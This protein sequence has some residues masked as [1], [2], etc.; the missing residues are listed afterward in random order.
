MK[1]LNAYSGAEILNRL[2]LRA[3]NNRKGIGGPQS[4]VEGGGGISRTW[5]LRRPLF[6][7]VDCGRNGCRSDMIALRSSGTHNTSVRRDAVLQGSQ[8]SRGV[9]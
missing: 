1:T 2:A 9:A 3:L 5:E 7:K 6:A 8:T 4:G